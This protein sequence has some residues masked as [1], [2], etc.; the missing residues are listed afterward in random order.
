MIS[1]EN[2]EIAFKSKSDADLNRAF[3]LFKIVGN[4]TIVKIGSQDYSVANAIE[5]KSSI[6]LDKL[7][8]T[9][10]ELVRFI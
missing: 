7:L 3:W 10:M 2:T 6:S 8:L 4:P 1:V 9:Q 5:R